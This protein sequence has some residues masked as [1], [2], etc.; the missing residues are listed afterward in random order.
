[1]NSAIQQQK[2]THQKHFSMGNY[3]QNEVN[4]SM[5]QEH[6]PID[7]SKPGDRSFYGAEVE[8]LAG[9]EYGNLPHTDLNQTTND[10]YQQQKMASILPNIKQRQAEG[11][12]QGRGFTKPSALGNFSGYGTSSR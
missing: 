7:S 2:P 3:S 1:M 10:A 4:E 8:P 9:F 5:R 6:A 12:S 11:M